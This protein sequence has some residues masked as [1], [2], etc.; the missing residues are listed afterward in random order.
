MKSVPYYIALGSL[1]W[2]QV[3]TYPNLLFLVNLLSYFIYNLEKIYWN[4]LKYV[5][6]YVKDTLDYRITYYVNSKLGSY[7]YIDSNFTRNKNTKR[8]PK[9]NVFFVVNRP[10]SWK[11]KC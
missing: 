3:T 4:A 11:T 9:G 7:S 10:V 2:L 1:I 6:F 5:L 8:L